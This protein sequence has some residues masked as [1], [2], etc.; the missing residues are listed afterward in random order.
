MLQKRQ[1]HNTIYLS[2]KLVLAKEQKDY[3][4]HRVN[5]KISHQITVSE[6]SHQTIQRINNLFYKIK[7]NGV[8]K[9]LSKSYRIREGYG[10]HNVFPRILPRSIYTS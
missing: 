2:R 9:D 7:M 6:N 5:I 8:E 4:S 10:Q 1:R 3:D